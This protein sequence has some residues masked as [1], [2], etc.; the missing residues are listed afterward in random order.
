MGINSN[1]ELFIL[2]LDLKKVVVKRDISDLMP[3]AQGQS[4]RALL[5]DGQGGI[6]F[7]GQQF[8]AKIDP[9]DGKIIK[10]VNVDGGVQVGGGIYNGVL[11]FVSRNNWKSI[12]LKTIF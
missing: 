8:L 11:Y 12:D 10:V 1:R 4:C 7:L 3:A 6:Y 5:R 2:D 9:A